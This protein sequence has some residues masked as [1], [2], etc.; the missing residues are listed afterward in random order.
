MQQISLLIELMRASGSKAFL[1]GD[2]KQGIYRFRGA[3]G[4]AFKEVA[5]AFRQAGK[6][7]TDTTHS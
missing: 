5:A 2:V 3:A 1:V 4:D 6:E 7:R